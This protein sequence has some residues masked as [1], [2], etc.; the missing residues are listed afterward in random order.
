[1]LPP[2][3]EPAPVIELWTAEPSQTLPG[4]TVKLSWRV[5]DAIAVSIQPEFGVV[6]DDG[7]RSVSPAQTTTYELTATGLG[8]TKSARITVSV[9]KP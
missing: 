3:V 2:P 8:G 1:M 5:R 6:E 4:D 9:A 7:S